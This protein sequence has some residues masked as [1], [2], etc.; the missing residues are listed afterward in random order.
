MLK[1]SFG[2]LMSA[3]LYV[4]FACSDGDVAGVTEQENAIAFEVETPNSYDLWSFGD[5]SLVVGNENLGH[6]FSYG[7]A[8]EDDGARVIFAGTTNTEL[9]ADDM[10]AVI[11]SCDGL[12]GTVEFG[13]S[14]KPASAGIGFTL[15]TDSSTLDVSAWNGLCVTYK[16]ELAMN[17]K[18][19]NGA[20]NEAGNESFV[21]FPKGKQFS[22]HCAKWEDFKQTHKKSASSES[23]VKKIGAILFEFRNEEK[24]NGSFNIKGVGS[25]KDIV[26][27][28]ENPPSSSSMKKLSSSSVEELSS[29]SVEIDTSVCLWN[30]TLKQTSVET[31]FNGSNA[32]H[33]WSFND[34]DAGGMSNIIWPIG[35]DGPYDDS[36]SLDLLNNFGCIEGTASLQSESSDARYVGVGFIVAGEQPVGDGFAPIAADISGWNGLCVTYASEKKIFLELDNGNE[37]VLSADLERSENMVEKCIAWDEFA[38]VSSNAE[39]T[40]R[41]LAGEI[42]VVKFVMKSDSNTNANFGIAA[43][44]K[45]S[46]DGACDVDLNKIKFTLIGSPSQVVLVGSTDN[47]WLGLDSSYNVNTRACDVSATCGYWYSVEDTDDGE[48]SR[49]TWPVTKGDAYDSESLSPII[50]YCGGLC[51]SLNF[52]SKGFAGVGFSIVNKD[53]V[54]GSMNQ[55][56][57]TSWGGL[58][59]KY[60]SSLNIDVVMNSAAREDPSTLL[61][62]P[63]V[64]LPKSDSVTTKC[65]AWEEFGADASSH[66]SSLLFV[67]EGD[68]G[69][70]GDFNIV[71]LGTLADN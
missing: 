25:Y 70:E 31:K 44:G 65:V 57:I 19:R 35:L 60:S 13:K 26:R 2:L 11:D 14:M 10:A 20:E 53:E 50:D 12:C 55:G 56:D 16:S 62:L 66:V 42:S 37:T 23:S 6:W 1:K 69:T 39:A 4:F 32:G 21:Q 64:T 9:S 47:L 28:Q 68:V 58:C 41:A 36:W 34:S 61:Q 33:W 29:S 38:N 45:Y 40:N 24:R 51:G 3:C 7:D 15:G 8:E 5:S 22:T 17:L 18:F 49:I 54:D 59:M 71:G 52:E 27:Q 30:G 43:V 48:P 63:M 46:A 67:F